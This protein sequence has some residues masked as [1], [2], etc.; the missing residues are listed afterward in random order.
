MVDL[1]HVTMTVIPAKSLLQ[2][3]SRGI[4][5]SI[6]SR[7]LARTCPRCAVRALVVGT[8]R[9]FSPCCNCRVQEVTDSGDSEALLTVEAFDGLPPYEIGAS[10]QLPSLWVVIW[11]DGLACGWQRV[12]AEH[13]TLSFKSC[14]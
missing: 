13:V 1:M 14:P 10:S 2:S 4:G 6:R 11:D 3:E 5:L 9:R 8:I 7:F 12:C